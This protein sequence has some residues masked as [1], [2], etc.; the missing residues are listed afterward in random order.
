MKQTFN[1]K[2]RFVFVASA[3]A[4][5]LTAC[6]QKELAVATTADQ[7]FRPQVEMV[8]LPYKIDAEADLTDTPSLATMDGLYAFFQETE[9]GYGDTIYLDLGDQVSDDR[10]D[11][12]MKFVRARGLAVGGPKVLGAKPENG[13]I[14]LY[15][16]RH[17]VTV[18][19]CGEWTDETH[20]D[21]RNN[22]SLHHGCSTTSSLGLM[23][24]DPRDLV[25]GRRGESNTKQA[26]KAVDR[27][28]NPQSGAPATSPLDALLSPSG[29]G[30]K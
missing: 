1:Q 13:T 5:L 24:A 12:I 22:A 26:I 9:A 6:S 23:V 30:S 29:S 28:N 21:Q 7:Q 4:G 19:N 10:L 15:I 8:R 25:T 3:L 14:Q 16:E 20:R 2:F 27:L 18:P 17:I 11:A